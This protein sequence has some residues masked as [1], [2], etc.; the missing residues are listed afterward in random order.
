MNWNN[1]LALFGLF[2]MLVLGSCREDD[3]IITTPVVPTASIAAAFGDKIDLENLANYANQSVPNYINRDN[4]AGNVITDAGATLGRVLFYDKQLSVNNTVSCA[5]CHQQ[6][7]AFSDAAIASTGV[8]GTTGRHSMRLVNARFAQEV[9]F[10]WDERAADLETQTTQ[11]IQDHAEMGFSGQNGAPGL[12]DLITKLE[13]LDYYQDLFTFVYGDPDITE[14]RM[15]RA[16]S[17]FI[18]SIQSFDSQYDVGRAQ[19]GNDGQDFPNF[20]AEENAGKQLFLA[21]PNLDA[22][23]RRTGL[24]LGCAGCH[25]PPAFDIDPNSHNNGIV[26]VIGSP[27][28]TDLTN[29]RSPTLRD[30]FGPDGTLNTPLMHTGEFSTL[31][32][33]LDHYNNITA[34]NV[35][36]DARLR[37]GPNGQQL[38]MTPAE[39]AAV[40]A[41]LKTLTGTAVYTDTRWGDPF[42]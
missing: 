34:V 9:R 37:R 26:R 2:A 11:P 30:L 24:G 15:Q 1:R 39:F 25:R 32:R 38:N 29:T 6:N 23:G 4:T 21:P 33:A 10:F 3:P 13:A 22:N 27:V 31:R 42:E 8:N 5:T 35:T 40:E 14:D 18:R 16:L 19:V 20:T 36:L 41:F 17:Q 28:L 7:L 12:T